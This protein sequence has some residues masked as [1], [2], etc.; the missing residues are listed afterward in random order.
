MRIILACIIKYSTYTIVSMHDEFHTGMLLLHVVVRHIV[1][2][3]SIADLLVATSHIWGATQSLENFMEAYHPNDTDVSTTDI[4]CT[5]QA[6]LAVI[7]TLASFLWT[8]AL[9]S[10]VFIVSSM[11]GIIVHC[12]TYLCLIHFILIMI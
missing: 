1:V 4:Q 12:D 7:G 10:Y 3:L 2:M 8:L 9:V 6:V 5:V 11:Q